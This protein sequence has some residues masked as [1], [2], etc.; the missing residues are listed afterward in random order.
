VHQTHYT[1]WT[2]HFPDFV[3][4]QDDALRDMIDNAE[5][6]TYPPRQQVFY[7]GKPCEHYLL[8]ISG[9][10]RVQM[11]GSQ[12]ML[13][14]VE[15]GSACVLTTSCLLCNQHY[16]AE[17]Y[18]ET[19]VTAFCISVPAFQQCMQQSPFFRAY[20]L[21]HF[22]TSFP[23]I[24][25]RMET[26]SLGPKERQLARLLL[27]RQQQG[28]SMLSFELDAL[29]SCNHTYIL[30]KLKRF[31]QMGW[32]SLKR[33]NIEIIDIKSLSQAANEPCAYKIKA[34]V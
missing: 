33:A 10:I 2:R 14:Q 28:L 24:I 12:H 17:A 31:E 5:L 30:E 8:L 9:R 27:E 29:M 15:P 11:S 16:P 3:E 1:L 25:R 13:Y 20:V 26:V 18:S 6:L 23:E 7:P 21:K 4:H 32:I 34:P 19:D 22:S